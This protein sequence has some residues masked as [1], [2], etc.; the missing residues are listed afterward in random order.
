M[1]SNTIK[2]IITNS[3][4]TE[5][6]YILDKSLKN[7]RGQVYHNPTTKKIIKK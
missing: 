4:N 3:Y 1:K 2:N 6:G 7:R 5:D